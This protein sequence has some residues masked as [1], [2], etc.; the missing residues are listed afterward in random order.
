MTASELGRSRLLTEASRRG[1]IVVELDERLVH[2]NGGQ[3]LL[4]EALL[5]RIRATAVVRG[6]TLI[7]PHTPA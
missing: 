3:V 7:A 4:V 2:G 6:R 1:D 5:R